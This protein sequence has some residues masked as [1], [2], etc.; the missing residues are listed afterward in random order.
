MELKTDLKADLA[1]LCRQYLMTVS[2]DMV[3]T[4][5]IQLLVSR[6]SGAV[7]YEN[8]QLSRRFY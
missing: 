8:N 1:Y 4:L 2:K 5:A 3:L 6:P 7:C